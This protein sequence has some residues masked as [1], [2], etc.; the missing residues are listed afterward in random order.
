MR[1]AVAVVPSMMT[2]S[3]SAMV[4]VPGVA[5]TKLRCPAGMVW[6]GMVWYGMVW[7]GGM[8]GMV[9]RTCSHSNTI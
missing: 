1:V 4:M 7:Y 9:S 3:P 2:L 6:Y 8:D 5:R